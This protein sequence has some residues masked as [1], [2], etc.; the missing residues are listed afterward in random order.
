MYERDPSRVVVTG[1]LAPYAVGLCAAV[2]HQGYT[3]KSSCE[4]MQLTAHLSRWMGARGV[5]PEALAGPVIAEFLAVR[6]RDY[7]KRTSSRALVPLL[8]HLRSVGAVPEALVPVDDSE[9]GVLLSEYRQYLRDERGVVEVSVRRYLPPVRAF[10]STVPLAQGLAGLTAE[11]VT[12]FVLEG[13][14]C[15]STADAK[16]M[17]TGLRSLLRFLF[18]TGRISR[19][20]AG[21]VPTVA[22][23]RLATLP[24]RLTAD[25]VNT[26]LSGC[27]RSTPAGRRDF[28][29][30]TVLSRLGLR[31]C[32]AAA[33]EIN[34]VDWRSGELTIRGKGGLT[35]RLP[36]PADVG[37]ALADYLMHGRPSDSSTS[38]LFLSG[39]APRQSVTASGIRALVA[40]GCKRTG[41]PRL[42]AHRLRHTVASDLLAAGAPLPEVGQVLRHRSQ[43]STA[44]YVKVDRVRL[45]ELARPWPGEAS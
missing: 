3:P 25:E 43:L 12:R 33:I 34:D 42:G 21:A 6:R 35:D 27:D 32:E 44:I 26:L 45:R 8:A 23:R 7:R 14:A 38:R 31:A 13:A 9:V 1:P 37:E 5:E 22:N 17:V 11:H 28:A 10:L 4:L 41:L 30:L 20:L 2:L 29:V 40:R 36:L 24:G 18:V 19:P 16:K 39:R 15:R